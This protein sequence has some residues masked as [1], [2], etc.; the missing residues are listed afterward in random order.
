MARVN[1]LSE[2]VNA[3]VEREV[4]RCLR[5]DKVVGVVGGDHSVPFGA[6]RALAARRKRSLWR[7]ALPFR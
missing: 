3:Y 2:Q 7:I 6:L 4:D 5:A 1:A